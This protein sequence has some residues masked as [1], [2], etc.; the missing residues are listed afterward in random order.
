LPAAVALR[1]DGDPF[2]A[3]LADACAASAWRSTR[4]RAGR[5]RRRRRCRGV[6]ARA[7]G[8]GLVAIGDAAARVLRALGHAVVATP[9]RHGRLVEC[10]PV[11]GIAVGGAAAVHGDALRDARPGRDAG[12]PRGDGDRAWSAWLRDA[13]GAPLVLAAR[14]RARCAS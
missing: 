9:P 3:A 13:D 14:R 12:R 11:E 2:A 1:A 7:S 8:R 4:R 5:P 10:V 6:R